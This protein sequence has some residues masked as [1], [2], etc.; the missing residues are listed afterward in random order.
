MYLN[1]LPLKEKSSYNSN[2]VEIKNRGQSSNLL[3]DKNNNEEKMIYKKIS[4]KSQ[5]ISNLNKP[6]LIS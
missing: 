3:G 6:L 1:S 2:K 4:G 5:E